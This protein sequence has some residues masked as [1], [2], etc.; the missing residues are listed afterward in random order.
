MIR[1]FK[2]YLSPRKIVFVTGEGLLIFFAVTLASYL[3]LGRETGMPIMLGMIWPKALLVSI[4]TQISLYHND[5][6]E[7][8]AIDNAID[9]AYRLIQSIGITSI[10]L[11]IIYFLLPNLIIARWVF[12]ANLIFLLFFL[13]CW[14]LVYSFVLEKKLFSEKAIL[15]GFGELAQNIIDEI[16]DQ[17]DLSYHVSFMVVHEKCQHNEI[18]AGE[19]PV[20]YGFDNIC[21]LAEANAVGNVIVALDEKRRVLPYEQLLACKVRG[22]NIIDG[23]SFYERIS[24]K[25]LIEKINPSWLIFSDGFTKSKISMFSKRLVGLIISTLL[26]IILIPFLLLVAVAIKLDSRGSVLFSQERVGQDEE[27]FTLYKFRSMRANAEKETGPVWAEEDD[28]RI[29]RVGEIIRKLRIDE[30]PQLWNIFK[31]DMSFVGPRPERLFFVEKL[32]KTIRYYNERAS[33]KPGVT[34]WAQVKYP[35]GSSEK[36]ALE[37]LKYD[38]YYIKNMSIVIDLIVFFHTIKIMLLGR[39]AR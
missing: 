36:D 12:F 21:D 25:L 5:L 27:I 32:K 11:A 6:Y 4:I 1:I 37:K 35:Y 10:I 31:G 24:G 18:Q 29:T 16:S 14:R 30:L 34:G 28:P 13:T 2:Q 8:N 9:L 26:L 20:H 39:G 3:F 19:I 33:V 23:E 7:I 22:I 38:L 17:K 15:V